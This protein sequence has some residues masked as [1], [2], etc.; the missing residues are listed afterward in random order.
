MMVC[1]VFSHCGRDHDKYCGVLRGAHLGV[2][3]PALNVVFVMVVLDPD[4]HAFQSIR[5]LHTVQSAAD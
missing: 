1:C 4:R 3:Q 2:L 5:K